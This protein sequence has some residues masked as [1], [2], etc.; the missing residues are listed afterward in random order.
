MAGGRLPPLERQER[1]REHLPGLA[2]VGLGGHELLERLDR[3]GR[4]AQLRVRGAEEERRG[5]EVRLQLQGGL[6]VGT[7]SFGRPAMDRAM[8]RFMRMPGS[9]GS[10]WTIAP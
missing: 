9:F 7:A 6:E 3:L 5:K 2:V 8:P 10:A 4:L 1:V